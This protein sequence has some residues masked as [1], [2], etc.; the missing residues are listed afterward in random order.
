MGVT[1]YP[2]T[3]GLREEAEDLQRGAELGLKGAE[4]FRGGFGYGFL[5][6]VVLAAEHQQDETMV[7]S[8]IRRGVGLNGAKWAAGLTH[9]LSS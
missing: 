4:V 7:E 5:E 3:S 2:W 9:S 8:E 6:L 1:W